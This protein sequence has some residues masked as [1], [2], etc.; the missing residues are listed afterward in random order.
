MSSKR[1][2]LPRPL[3]QFDRYLLL[4]N[5][6]TWSARTHLVLWYGF[7]FAAALAGLAWLEPNDP[8]T[9]THTGYWVGFVSLVSLIALV[10]W[11]I[12]LLRF[13]VFKRFGR[14]GPLMR[15]ATF[16]LYF[17]SIGTF[18]FF[19]YV[20]PILETARANRAY[21]DAEI[22]RDINDINMNLTRL[23]Y[24]SL[25]HRWSSDTVRVVQR[26]LSNDESMHNATVHGTP[27]APAGP[28][29][30]RIIDSADLRVKLQEEDSA[31]RL[32]DSVY[33]FFTAP[34]YTF[35]TS[36]ESYFAPLSQLKEIPQGRSDVLDNR[37]IYHA[38]VARYRP[39]DPKALQGA[40]DA[41]VAKYAVGIAYG[42]TEY[43]QSLEA[44][45]RDRHSLYEIR[46]AMDNILERKHRWDDTLPMFLRMHLYTTLVLTLL[47]F[48]FR[49]STAR[50]FFLSLLAAVVLSILTALFIGFSGGEELA[51]FG[52]ILFYVILFFILSAL[53]LRS[54]RRQ[55]VNGIGINLL[56]WILPFAPF[57]LTALYQEHRRRVLPPNVFDEMAAE[58]S[59]LWAES[60]GV[61]LFLLFVATYFHFVYRRWYAAAEG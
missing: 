23:Y 20:Q 16:L 3:R 42:S 15:L 6:E 46:Q 35:L 54:R 58:R 12:Y 34:N 49:H 56:A 44:R 43:D 31:Q 8:R 2:L 27:A 5:P 48:T 40:L 33:A 4:H 47:A 61:I 9:D 13:N 25:P 10:I 17:I 53:A 14:T 50:T 55:L 38:V 19:P 29:G 21:T 52:W 30:W 1:P 57:F 41:A 32:S 39:S 28:G 18:A 60:G 11:A 22:I 26:P 51:G 37:A 45:I 59:L 24:D 36:Y 7:L